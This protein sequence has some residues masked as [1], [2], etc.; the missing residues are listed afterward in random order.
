MARKSRDANSSSAETRN[1]G[2]PRSRQAAVMINYL[3]DKRQREGQIYLFGKWS[4]DEG[5]RIVL[6]GPAVYRARRSRLSWTS[7]IDYDNSWRWGRYMAN[8]ARLT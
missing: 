6:Q 1:R 8:L 4:G 7:T 3:N 2:S 5:T